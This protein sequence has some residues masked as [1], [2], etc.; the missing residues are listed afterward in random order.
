MTNITIDNLLPTRIF[1]SN[2]N[3]TTFIGIDFG[4]STTVVSIAY[5]DQATGR[6][7]TKAIP[8]KQELDSGINHTSEK[9]PTVI[10]YLKAI[11]K[12]ANLWPG[13]G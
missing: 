2:I 5:F 4:T 11:G 13:C 1:N 3:D 10:A 9:T 6:F 7:S 12:Q 8:I